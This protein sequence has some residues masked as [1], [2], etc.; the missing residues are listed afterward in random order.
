MIK[1]LLKLSNSILCKKEVLGKAF[2]CKIGG[3]KASLHFPQFPIVDEAKSLI[4]ISNPL[5]APKIENVFSDQG[6][7]LF[8]GTPVSYPDGNS[9]LFAT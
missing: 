7:V 4:G 3:I 6:D 1:G 8:W 5:L 9:L 2:E